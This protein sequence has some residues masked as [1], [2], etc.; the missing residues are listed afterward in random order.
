[1]AKDEDGRI[2]ID[3]K[4]HLVSEFDEEDISDLM[5]IRGAIS[6]ERAKEWLKEIEEM[7]ES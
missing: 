1:M 7:R 2:V 6:N 3:L 5:G 4:N